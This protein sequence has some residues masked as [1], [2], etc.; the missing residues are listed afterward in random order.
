MFQISQE[1]LKNNKQGQT[2]LKI[3][4]KNLKKLSKIVNNFQKK[5]KKFKNGFKGP[6]HV[7][8]CPI[9]SYQPYSPGVLLP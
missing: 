4:K 3:I 8:S 1:W 5:T 7:L 9:M 2:W 6:N